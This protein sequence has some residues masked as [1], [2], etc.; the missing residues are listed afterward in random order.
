MRV[1]TPASGVLTTPSQPATAGGDSR[2]RPLAHTYLYLLE[3]AFLRCFVAL[4]PNIYISVTTING[5]TLKSFLSENQNATLI[6]FV[7]NVIRLHAL[8][9]GTIL[10]HTIRYVGTYLV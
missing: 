10:T 5:I 7:S 3:P 6:H 8:I 9:W 4:S 2:Q 1:G